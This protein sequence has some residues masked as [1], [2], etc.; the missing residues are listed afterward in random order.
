MPVA[1]LT[2]NGGLIIAAA[3]ADAAVSGRLDATLLPAADALCKKLTTDIVAQKG[4]KGGL[5]QLTQGQLLAL[6][7]LH[8]CLTQAQ[9]TA[10]LAFPG[11]T[12]LHHQTFQTGPHEHSDLGSFLSR[13]DIVL[14]GVKNNLAAFKTQGWSDKETTAFQTARDNFGPAEHYRE[15]SKGG[16]M[17]KTAVKN[18]D[19]AQLYVYILSIQ[20]AAD[21]E[22]PAANP[23]NAGT[24]AIFR[25][26]IFPPDHGGNSTPAPEPGPT[27]PPKV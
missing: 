21:L 18:T 20:N 14:G 16:A 15:T 13:V 1:V 22:Y 6:D 10:K 26:G 17:D 3:Q 27:Q 7:T 19:A 12:V 25:L 2:H 4:A 23:A 8:H 24:R 11:D 9:K 5:G